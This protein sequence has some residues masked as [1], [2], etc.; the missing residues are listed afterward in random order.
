MVTLGRFAGDGI[1]VRSGAVALART[2]LV[3]AIAGVAVLIGASAMWQAIVGF[4]LVGLGVS[5]IFP[6]GVS[7]T[8]RLSP[9]N[10][11]RSGLVRLTSLE[12]GRAV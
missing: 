8:A 6:L 12:L 4:G 11:A 7:A 2:S 5:T 9:T 3:L 1:C 10:K